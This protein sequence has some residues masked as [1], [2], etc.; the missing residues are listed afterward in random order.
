MNLFL[1]MLALLIIALAS[2][3][4]LLH[5]ISLL[6]FCFV[7]TSLLVPFTLASCLVLLLTLTYMYFNLA[8][9]LL[10]HC[11]S[12]D[13]RYLTL[14]PHK[15]LVYFDFFFPPFSSEIKGRPFLLLNDQSVSVVS[16]LPVHRF[17]YCPC[18][19]SYK[20]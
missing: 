11:L 12:P 4:V 5:V 15:I 14:P 3:P 9:N 19:P 10:K 7:S 2:L 20:L 18:H 17:S 16:S 6:A 8:Q 1:L 13:N